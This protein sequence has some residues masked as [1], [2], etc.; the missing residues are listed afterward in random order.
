MWHLEQL[1]HMSASSLRRLWRKA[2][3][4]WK[5]LKAETFQQRMVLFYF[6]LL[7]S[8]I[9]VSLPWT[10]NIHYSINKSN[11][12]IIWLYWFIRVVRISHYGKYLVKINSIVTI[13][14]ITG[15]FVRNE[16]RDSFLASSLL[17]GNLTPEKMNVWSKNRRFSFSYLSF[18]LPWVRLLLLLVFG[19]LTDLVHLEIPRKLWFK[20]L[21][22]E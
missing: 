8:I 9:S 3:P 11:E 2:R 18:L 15:H 12:D 13:K 20:T 21:N 7:Q 16:S 1:S 6:F 19:H 10:V 5:C 14:A 17:T 22:C 4:V